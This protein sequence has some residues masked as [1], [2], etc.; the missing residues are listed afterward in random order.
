MC[1]NI[2]RK[3]KR[4]ILFMKTLLIVNLIALIVLA[5]CLTLLLIK[6]FKVD[7]ALFHTAAELNTV[8]DEQDKIE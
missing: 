7:K 8:K 5:I 4:G 6:Y 3:I 1:Y 2:F